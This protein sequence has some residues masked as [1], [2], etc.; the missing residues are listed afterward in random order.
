MILAIRF[1]RPFTIIII[2]R[3]SKNIWEYR[4][5]IKHLEYK[6]KSIKCLRILIAN[7]SLY[8][9]IEEMEVRIESIIYDIIWSGSKLLLCHNIYILRG[10]FYFI[11]FLFFLF[12]FFK[13][14]WTVFNTNIQPSKKIIN[15]VFF[16]LNKHINCLYYPRRNTTPIHLITINY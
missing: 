16:S 4:N 13:F 10:G 7:I 1:C 15:C 11:F 9:Y 12:L 5:N 3:K 8:I 6:K 2:I 14:R